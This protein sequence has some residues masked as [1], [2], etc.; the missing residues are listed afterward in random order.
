MHKPVQEQYISLKNRIGDKVKIVCVS[1]YAS[2]E[3][4]KELVELKTPII[5][6]ENKVQVA[7]EKL[8]HFKQDTHIEWHFI[9]HLQRNKVKKVIE[10]FDVIQS[11]DSLRLAEA[12]NTAA[13]LQLK[14]Q[15]IFV[16]INFSSEK[17]K[18][19]IDPAE[20]DH[21]IQEIQKLSHIR[22]EGIMCMAPLNPG[23]A[24]LKHTFTQAKNYF[25]S[26][27]HNLSSL[28]HVSMGM[29]QDYSQA[30]ACGSTMIRCG[31]LIFKERTS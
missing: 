24:V 13:K 11:V 14:T 20:K 8:P 22:V 15:R 17:Q 3:A 12:I 28:N 26:L 10:H 9:G 7:L 2:V 4:M 31:S 25:D 27:K 18:F 23:D 1:K 30:I 29:S 19:G 16:Q 21:L 6:G 5:F